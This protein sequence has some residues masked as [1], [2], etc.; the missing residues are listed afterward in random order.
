V[1]RGA[2]HPGFEA[3]F[4]SFGMKLRVAPT[5]TD[6]RQ[7]NCTDK[8]QGARTDVRQSDCTDKR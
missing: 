6:M 3:A 4:G 8:R 5:R 1:V 2:E 7:N